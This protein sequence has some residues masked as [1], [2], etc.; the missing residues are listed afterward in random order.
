MYFIRS[1][2]GIEASIVIL[3]FQ[4]HVVSVISPEDWYRTSIVGKRKAFNREGPMHK[5]FCF[6]YL[7]YF[8]R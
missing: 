8:L 5:V 7:Y 2:R 3:A 6:F 1:Y 4:N